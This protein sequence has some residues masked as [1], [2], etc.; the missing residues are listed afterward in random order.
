MSRKQALQRKKERVRLEGLEGRLERLSRQG[1]DESF[2]DLA[3]G[4]TRELTPAAVELCGQV[5]DR[6]LRRALA[7]ADLPRVQRLLSR[8]DR[9]LRARPLAALAE[10]VLHLAE[11]RLE[12]AQTRLAALAPEEAGG[13]PWPRGLAEALAVLC[14]PRAPEEAPEAQA[15]RR[16]HR[17]LA[18]F[19][20]RELRPLPA[21]VEVLRQAAEE[22]RQALPTDPAVR[23]LSEAALERLRLMAGLAGL[24]EALAHRKGA[25]FLPFFLERVKSLS[26]ALLAVLRD[27]PPE[28]LL[29]PLHHALRLRWRDLLALVAERQGAAAWAEAH[30]AWPALAAVDLE[31][32]GGPEGARNR[33]AVRELRKAGDHGQ[34]ARLLGSLAGAEKA[35]GRMAL[36]WSLELWA[37]EQAE[38]SGREEEGWLPVAAEPPQH[39]ALVRVGRMARDLAGRLPAEQRPEVA[40]FLRDRLFELLERQHFCRHSL[41]AADALLHQIP[42]DPGLLLVALTAAA[43]AGDVRAQ[44]LFAARLA[45]RGEA[46]AA[47]RETVLRLVSQI[48]LERAEV[49]AR[50]LPPL[51]LLL[52]DE[53]WP[54]ALEIV[55]RSVTDLVCGA[56]ELPPGE[57]DLHRLARDLGVYRSALADRPELE[58]L[59]A[60]LACV[61]P[62]GG[63]EPLLRGLLDRTP[64]LE[65]A[66]IALRVLG[67]ASTPWAPPA[68]GKA[69]EDAREAVIS[70]LDLR[71]RLWI[72]VL[73]GLLIG[74]SRPQARRLRVRIVGL[75]RS[76]GL[77]EEDRQALEGSLKRIA[78]LQRIASAFRRE[79]AR[80]EAGRRRRKPRR[81]PAAEQLGF[82]LF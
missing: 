29:R 41:E 21:E 53:G 43:C 63:G 27:S 36:L 57:A 49:L 45:A 28:A 34:L 81:K 16:F 39:A 9:D 58:A 51:R 3:R 23:R 17:A 76:K 47:E 78:E 31:L 65:P 48:A 42:G 44:G 82:D 24:E 74:A 62:G 20:D 77:Q 18:A 5:A 67:A 4:R 46:R 26:S 80:A 35:P 6:A 19:E 8:I 40:R 55:L 2:L 69:F 73:P 15:I 72:P 59:E 64:Q 79:R 60:A 33:A 71:W 54:G 10:S 14:A 68:V 61:R 25:A 38:G 1:A 22:L 32:G 70:R 12:K 30:A 37:W 75:L 50:V 13:A 52:G 66:L 7:G 56:L 11:G